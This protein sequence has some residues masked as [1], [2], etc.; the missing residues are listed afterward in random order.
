MLS[1]WKMY[2][3]RERALELLAAVQAG[4]RA[5][6]AADRR[7][8]TVIVCPP[9]VSL[10]P[11]RAALEPGLL[12]LG[13]QDCHWELEGPYTGETSAATLRG[14]ADYVL[15]GHSERRAAGDTDDRIAG[16]VAAAAAA[17]VIPILFV[18]EDEP[19]DRAVE[20]A[21]LRLAKGLSCMDPARHEVLVVYEPTWAIGAEEAAR[22]DHVQGVVGQL[23]MRLTELGVETPRVIYG[24]TVNSRNV[25]ELVAVEALDGVGATRAGLDPREF[26]HII[27]RV[28]GQWR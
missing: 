17:G 16:K 25:D 15:V 5:R 21:E 4:L 11:L 3:T 18:G 23:K 27:D 2:P 22:P 12:K 24:G 19:T 28:A 20:Q 8:V 9:F 7:E 14:L 1:N 26:L 13:A 6:L 10:V